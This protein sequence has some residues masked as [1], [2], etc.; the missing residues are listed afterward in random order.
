MAN[1]QSIYR[2]PVKG[3]TP[4]PW[5]ARCSRRGKPFPATASMPSRTARPASI[6]PRP[7]YL[8]KTHFL[9]LMKNERFANL[10]ASFDQDSHTLTITL[11]SPDRSSDGTA[12]G[13]LRTTDGRAKIEDFFA[14]YCA[15]ELRGPPKILHSEGHS[16][17]DVARKVISFINLASVAAVENMV[18]APVNPLTLSRQRLCRRLAGLE[19]ARP[20]RQGVEHRRRATQGR[21]AHRPLRRHQC[22]SRHRGTRPQ[23]SSNA[24][25]QSRSRRLRNL[26]RGDRGRGDRRGRCDRRVVTTSRGAPSLVRTDDARPT[27]RRLGRDTSRR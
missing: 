16:F 26:C 21:Q 15:G 23:Y 20:R 18:G 10:R 4:E 25:A 19:R 6:R 2:Y 5:H 27:F 24:D 1:I 14:T 8:S 3:L 17:S 9:M 13:D 7:S 12:T 11:P 22:R